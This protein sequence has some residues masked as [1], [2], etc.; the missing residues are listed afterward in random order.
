MT[1]LVP[2]LQT[3]PDGVYDGELVAFDDGIPWFPDVCARLLD[4][5]RSVRLVYMVFDVLALDGR[6]TM[7]LP[8]SERRRLLEQLDL[9]AAAVVSDR[10]DDGGALFDVV[11]ERGLEGVVAKRLDSRYAPG[12]RGW[13]KAKNR[14]TWWR[15]EL[16]RE[17]FSSSRSSASALA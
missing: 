11:C 2:E 12:E 5:D 17:S 14:E 8:Y 6:E 1:A 3:L 9:P 4:G 13:V 10:F 16:E 7:R 15:Y